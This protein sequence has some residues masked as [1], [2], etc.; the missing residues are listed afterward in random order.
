MGILGRFRIKRKSF[1]QFYKESR[2][3]QDVD[4]MK[5][6]KGEVFSGRRYISYCSNEEMGCDALMREDMG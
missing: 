2:K 6:I 1:E 5:G 3:R 4:L